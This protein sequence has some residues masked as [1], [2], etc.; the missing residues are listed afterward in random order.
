[1]LDKKLSDARIND[2]AELMVAGKKTHSDYYNYKVTA[3]AKEMVAGTWFADPTKL[4]AA[5]KCQPSMGRLTLSEKLGVLYE[6]IC[7]RAA[8]I[9]TE[10]RRKGVMRFIEGLEGLT[11]DDSRAIVPGDSDDG[12][13]V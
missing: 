9:R 5:L 3:M 7:E 4:L 8:E 2:Q 6:N 11:A 13:N 10:R 12:G 1:M